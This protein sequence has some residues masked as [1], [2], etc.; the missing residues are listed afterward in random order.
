MSALLV[1]AMCMVT[2]FG[3]IAVVDLSVIG[4]PRTA[5]DAVIASDVIA[6]LPRALEG[7]AA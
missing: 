4:L 2:R 5:P 7:E 1:T 6:A 3:L